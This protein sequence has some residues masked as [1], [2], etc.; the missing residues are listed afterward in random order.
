MLDLYADDCA[1]EDVLYHL[2]RALNTNAATLDMDRFFKVRC[3]PH[4]SARC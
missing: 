4:S 3:E 1:L 2:G